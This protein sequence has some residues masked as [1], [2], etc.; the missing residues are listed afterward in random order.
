M[1]VGVSWCTYDNLG[2]ETLFVGFICG[3][4]FQD[5]R[6]TSEV[7]ENSESMFSHFLY[8]C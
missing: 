6:V 5:F 7:D 2:K 3:Y 1:I 8:N 4:S